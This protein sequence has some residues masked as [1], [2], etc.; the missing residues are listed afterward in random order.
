MRRSVPSP[1]RVFHRAAL[2][3]VGFLLTSSGLAYAYFSAT[4]VG[5]YGIAKAGALSAP[6]LSIAGQSPASGGDADGNSQGKGDQNGVGQNLQY[7]QH[8]G[9]SEDGGDDDA[10]TGTTTVILTWQPPSNPSGTTWAITETG[11]TTGSGS[12]FTEASPRPTC[13]VTGLSASKPYSFQLSYTLYSWRSTSNIV[14]YSGV[15]GQKTCG[16]ERMTSLAGKASLTFTVLGGGGGAGGSNGGVGGPGAAIHGTLYNTNASPVTVIYEAGCV[17]TPGAQPAGG[18]GG[19]GYSSGGPGGASH[20]SIGG[21]GGGGGGA[22]FLAVK[23][24]SVSKIV[25]VAGGGGGGGGSKVPSSHTGKVGDSNTELGATTGPMPGQPGKR[26]A[27]DGSGGMGTGG[28]GGGAGTQALGGGLTTSK[29]PTQTPE[30]TAGAGGRGGYNFS[31]TGT[32][33]GVEVSV[34]AVVAGAN[35]GTTG[36]VTLASAPSS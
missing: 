13:T 30:A 9:K 29:K 28:A 20:T 19:T 34:T 22:S 10:G 31:R 23:L 4:S 25:A 2:V 32:V 11:T 8:G 27:N 14:T 35:T 3:A 6:L 33:T 36:A 12:C 7:G 21:G 24:G 17:G 1:R 16:Q 18:S 26:P 5:T 15:P